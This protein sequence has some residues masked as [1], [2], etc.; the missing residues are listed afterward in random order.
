MRNK[1]CAAVHATLMQLYFLTLIT[2]IHLLTSGPGL[3]E[4]NVAR[5]TGFFSVNEV[6]SIIFASRPRGNSRVGPSHSV[7]L[8]RY[9]KWAASE[10]KKHGRDIEV[11]NRIEQTSVRRQRAA[12]QP[13]Q[14]KSREQL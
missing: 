7:G 5:T 9:L 11:S 13:R 2:P 4:L 6:S 3:E 1:W 10:K 8:M 14:A 12:W